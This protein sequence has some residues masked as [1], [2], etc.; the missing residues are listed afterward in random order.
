MNH[1]E[2]VKRRVTCVSAVSLVVV[3]YCERERERK[4]ERERERLALKMGR[5]RDDGECNDDH[6]WDGQNNH[7]KNCLEY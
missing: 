2:R 5:K 3:L 1:M 7:H 6:D 4:R